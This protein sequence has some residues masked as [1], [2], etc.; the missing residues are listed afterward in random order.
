MSTLQPR[1]RPAQFFAYC[2]LLIL[3]FALAIGS[4]L[5]FYPA[6]FPQYSEP[7][8]QLFVTPG[9]ARST[10]VSLVAGL[11]TPAASLV[12]VFSF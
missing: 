6:F 9:I 1:N 2:L 4:G 10:A 7:F 3:G 12:S 11:L 8:A 5:A